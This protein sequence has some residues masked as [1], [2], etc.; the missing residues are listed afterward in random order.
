[1]EVQEWIVKRPALDRRVRRR[2]E[3]RPPAL[4]STVFGEPP[5]HG[6][7]HTLSLVIKSFSDGMEVHEPIVK[8]PALDRRRVERTEARPPALPSTVFREPPHQ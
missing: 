6:A 8:R 4:P 3:A 2:T 1:M 7:T 5:H